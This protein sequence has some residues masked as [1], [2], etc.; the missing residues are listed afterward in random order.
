MVKSPYISYEQQFYIMLVICF[1]VFFSFKKLT[2][3]TNY[4]TTKK[5]GTTSAADAVAPYRNKITIKSFKIIFNVIGFRNWS[6]MNKKKNGKNI[7][8]I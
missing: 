8:Q 1:R 2:K 4:T 7:K 6:K 5:I 3:L